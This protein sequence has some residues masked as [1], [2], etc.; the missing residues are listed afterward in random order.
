MK[1]PLPGKGTKDFWLENALPLACTAAHDVCSQKALWTFQELK[2]H[3]LAF[4]ESSVA[5]LLNC[6]K[7]DK[8]VF[9]GRAL[10]EAISF[11]SVEPLDCSLLFHKC[12]SFR[13]SF[14]D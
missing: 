5:I 13:L 2:F 10:N 3:G 1:I 9:S 14:T 12:N 7:V 6:G 11:G 4:V 8:D